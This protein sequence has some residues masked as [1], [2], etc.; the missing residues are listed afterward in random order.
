MLILKCYSN[1][2]KNI[3][4]LL[5]MGEFYGISREVDMAKGKYKIP[6]SWKEVK[7][8]IKRIWYGR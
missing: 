6:Y 1:M 7:Q 3:I 4:D 2:I 8:Q 5:A